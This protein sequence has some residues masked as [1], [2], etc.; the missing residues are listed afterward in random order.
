[1]DGRGS[2]VVGVS[3]AE[4]GYAKQHDR[5]HRGG[6]GRKNRAPAIVN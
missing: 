5:A 2:R 1:M 6:C 3:S 4:E